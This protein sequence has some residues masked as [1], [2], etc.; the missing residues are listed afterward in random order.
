MLRRLLR[1]LTKAVALLL[2][3]AV[4]AGIS[5]WIVKWIR[6]PTPG[7]PEELVARADEL[8]WNND[9]AGA[10]PLYAKAETL[11]REKGDASH[12]LY[13]QVSR[14]PLLMET[15]SLPAL[16]AEL[17]SDL[18]LAA[19]SD[20]AVRLR[21]LEVKGR[22]EEEY[23]A[24]LAAKTFAEVQ[25]LALA[26]F[27]LYLA[28]RASAERGIMLFTRG[29]FDEARRLVM[30]AY[31]VASYL[32]DP[33]AHV[34]YASMIGRGLSQMG[35]PKQA[36]KY[37]DEAIAMQK[38][39]PQVASPY[40]AIS[41]K[42]DCLS[43]LGRNGEALSLAD[44]ELGRLKKAGHLG[45]L[46][47][48]LTTRAGVLIRAGRINEAIDDYGEAL[49]YATR[50]SAWRAVTDI[51]GELAAAYRRSGD[52][53]KA[54]AAVNDAIDANGHAGDEI[55]LVPGIL[56]LKAKILS[57]MG[58]RSE[59]ESVYRKGAQMVDLL[60]SAVPTVDIEDSVLAQMGT[61]Y[62]GYFQL[63][64]DQGRLA[65]AFSVIE[66][67]RGRIEEQRLN[68][69][70]TTVP[71]SGE[72]E[73]S[74]MQE[75]A[76]R[77]LRAKDIGTEGLLLEQAHIRSIISA[78][79]TGNR[80]A[81]LEK[82]Q[83][84]LREG[85]LL[86]EYIL[87]EPASFALVVTKSTVKRFSLP[88]KEQI[89]TDAK[90]YRDVMLKRSAD[91]DRGQKLFRELLSFLP[92]YPDSSSVIAI[93]DGDLHLLPFSALV[94]Q[95]GQYLAQN[96]TIA[97]TPSG[98]VLCT[99]RDRAAP[100]TNE[101]KSYLGVAPWASDN[102]QKNWVLARSGG[103]RTLLTPLP[104]TRDEVESIAAMMP[105][106]ATVLVGDAATKKKFASLPLRDYRV[107]HLALHGLVDPVF[108]DRSALVFAPTNSD[109]GRLEAHDIRNLHLR[110]D[111]VTL[112]AC[113]TGVGPA[114]SAGVQSLHTAFIEAGADTV[115]SSL[116][117]LDDAKADILMKNFYRLLRDEDKASALRDAE[118]ELM[119]TNESPYYWAAFEIV[120]NPSG[121]PLIGATH[122]AQR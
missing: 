12:G 43:A 67:G 21:I 1:F 101:S 84:D 13:A 116:W 65:E 28:S 97:M 59:A 70:S 117:E 81:S 50:L 87:T 39:Y 20:S 33:A 122:V 89:E 91:R 51:E 77:L 29:K 103:D 18:K 63:L 22:C 36:L 107:L 7:S 112:S 38:K 53:P 118:L 69:D 35:R 98:T 66:Q 72:D 6:R 52:L 85:E 74:R 24:G 68:F 4:V 34:R 102:G 49:R 5:F 16:I 78:D 100:V 46:Q 64:S 71:L 113:N 92:H 104:H 17:N 120:G 37:L 119:Q 115:V 96:K 48:L 57:D 93:A 3:A 2:T 75:F 95:S 60:L 73:Q 121:S 14:V 106:E 11:F 30:Q 55:F 27:R 15:T 99:L 31:L 88:S 109:D 47:S 94:D 79:A 10:A 25:A 108:P 90:A 76:A 19:A 9:W 26:R 80:V 82:L 41:A 61:L 45:Q 42:V 23:D 58:K 40:V 105:K 83:A 110:A 54:L 44:T 86:V 114:S 111:L 8:A 56:A 32:H 62:A